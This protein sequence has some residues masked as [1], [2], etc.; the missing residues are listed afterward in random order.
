MAKGSALGII[1]LLIGIGGLG[2]G[3]YSY[4]TVNQDIHIIKTDSNIHHTYFDN[5]TA[6]YTSP[7]EDI[8]YEIAN[9]SITFQ[10]EPGESV[11][12]LFTCRAVLS[13]P[14]GGNFFMSFQLKIDG[15]AIIPSGTT[16]GLVAPT[17]TG[18]SYSVTLQYADSSL[19]AGPH[20]VIV[21][22]Y[23]TCDGYMDNCFLLVQTFIA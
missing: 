22:T 20:N 7:G 4:F 16:V 13:T 15:V 11:Y 12:F 5:R 8:W 18:Y 1:A 9:I 14:T 17:D 10:V 6:T 23:R 2:F 3:I 21:I 19:T